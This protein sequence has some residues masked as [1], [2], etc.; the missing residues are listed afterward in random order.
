MRSESFT[1]E[2]LEQALKDGT[3][4]QSAPSLVAMVKQSE[5]AG[6]VAITASGCE[7]WIDVPTAML[8]RV[9]RMGR[10]S[11]KDHSHPLMGITFKEPRD[12]EA[13]ILLALLSQSSAA[14][15]GPHLGAGSPPD[16]P[17][18]G[19]Y[20]LTTWSGDPTPPEAVPLQTGG[21]HDTGLDLV[22]KLGP[23]FTRTVQ[24]TCVGH[25]S[26]FGNFRIPCVRTLRCCWTYGE[27]GGPKLRCT[28][29]S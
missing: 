14:G 23:C 6:H 15:C 8:E 20:D 10:Q 18:G 11:C 28:Y 1:G 26:W 4:D 17:L 22:V 29:I 13:R 9:D 27:P 12:P 3:L 16:S 21:F 19:P 24:T 2:S 5:K 7:T 25:S